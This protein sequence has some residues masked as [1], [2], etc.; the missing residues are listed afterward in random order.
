MASTTFVDGSTVI[1]A[2]WLNDVNGLVYSGTF[3]SSTVSLTGS[4]TVP[5]VKSNTTLTLQSNGSTPCFY[6]DTA[7]NVGLSTNSLVSGF[8]VTSAGAI[9]ANG[10]FTAYGADPGLSSGS[11][12]VFMDWN[13]TVGRIGTAT[14]TGSGGS[15]SFVVSNNAVGTL[16]GSGN[17]SV[18]GQFNGAG[19]G[20]TGTATSLSIGGTSDHISNSGYNGYGLRTVSTSSPSGGSNGDIWYQV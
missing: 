13:G 4:V 5:V 15:L 8:K 18:N 2:S 6:A 11:S 3:Q 7:Q 9:I 16:D 14:G 20:L 17:L 19:T 10:S 1:V 12:R